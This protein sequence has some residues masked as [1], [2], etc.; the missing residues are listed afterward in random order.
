M[1]GAIGVS[2]VWAV[3]LFFLALICVPGQ[4][5]AIVVVSIVLMNSLSSCTKAYNRAK[6]VNALPPQRVANYM[7]WDSLNKANQGGIAI[8][9]GQICHIW[10]YRG[11]FA[12]TL[13]ILIV[14]WSVWTS[15]LAYRGFRRYRQERQGKRFS[16]SWGE[17]EVIEDDGEEDVVYM[18][19]ESY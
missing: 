6:L 19:R 1:K 13:A 7:V 15:Y 18:L 17:D 2:V 5:F 11:C 16:P 9:G 4:N 14:R 10:G 12:V 8:F 3:S